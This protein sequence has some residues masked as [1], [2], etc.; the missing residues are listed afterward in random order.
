MKLISQIIKLIFHCD[1]Q[2]NNPY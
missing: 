1:N 2:S